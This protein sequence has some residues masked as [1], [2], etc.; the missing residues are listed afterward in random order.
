MK[1]RFMLVN[2]IDTTK[3]IETAE[4]PLGLGYLASSLRENFG[5]DYIDF[6]VVDRDI[7]Q[8]ISE[9]KPT[10]VGITSVSQNYN[11][12]IKYA[13]IAKKY[14]LP[15][16]MGGIHIS[17]LPSTLTEDMD[18]GVIGEGEQAIV[19]LFSL[20]E[21]DGYFDRDK[22]ENISG[23]VFRKNS[24][25]IVTKKRNPIEPL[26][27]ISM[28][29]RDLFTINK[30][31]YMFTS[32]GCPYR[33]TFCASSR[34]W[35]KLRFFSAEYVVNEIKY[36]VK[37]YST[38]RI[39]FW[40]DLFIADKIR[41]RQILELLQKEN[42][43]GKVSFTCTARSNLV[44]DD[45]AHLLKKMNVKSVGMGLESA[46]PATLEYL[47]GGDIN[48]G[49]HRNA[50]K[51]LRKYGIESCASFIIGSPEESQ[52]DILQTLRFIKEN[53][54]GSIDVYVL[55]PFPGTPVWEYAKAKNLVS[56]DMDWST[57]NVNFGENHNHAIILSEGI[58]REEL[59]KLF[60]LFVDEKKKI[61][62][63][64]VLRDPSVLLSH[65]KFLKTTLRRILSR[66]P[67][68]AR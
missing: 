54:L 35:D 38:K 20:F 42:L 62:I 23:V 63:R 46:V 29:A 11:K 40:D 26:D 12:A 2:A 16:I 4:P 8:A 22:L 53:P 15:V 67:L 31:T 41:L 65:Q 50:V 6:K 52:E 25:L 60:L 21:E 55:T 59:Y 1:P 32:R 9:F 10:I 30:S 57:L 28:P 34:F 64:R 43:L 49:N 48:P 7:R 19:E 13:G 45:L 17:T 68:F 27:N 44:N 47:K 66:Q 37:K 61:M 14:S 24:K 51:I 18:V 36:L 58:T 39:E 56:E 3:Q 5:Q 33:C